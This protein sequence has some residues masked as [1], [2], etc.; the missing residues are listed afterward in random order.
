ML[1]VEQAAGGV[2]IDVF[3]PVRADDAGLDCK[4]KMPAAWQPAFDITASRFS[5]L[6]N[7]RLSH[8]VL[9]AR[10]YTHSSPRRRATR[11]LAKPGSKIGV[12]VFSLRFI[13]LA[14]L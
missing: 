11:H 12:L 8:V 4:Q 14:N 9:F 7:A 5:H 10:H 2:V 1:A 6:S 13:G 3:E